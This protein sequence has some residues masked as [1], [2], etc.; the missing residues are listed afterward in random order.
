[1]VFSYTRILQ[2]LGS[3]RARF[4]STLRVENITGTSDSATG[5]PNEKSVIG[6]T[7]VLLVHNQTEENND[8][9]AV[10]ASENRG[11]ATNEAFETQNSETDEPVAVAQLPETANDVDSETADTLRTTAISAESDTDT[12]AATDKYSSKPET[13][14]THR[15]DCVTGGVNNGNV[16]NSVE[17]PKDTDNAT[18]KTICEVNKRISGLEI[19]GISNLSAEGP[20]NTV[21]L[22]SISK[23][24][25]S[26]VNEQK[27]Y[28]EK[29]PDMASDNNLSAQSNPDTTQQMNTSALRRR[30]DVRSRAE[31]HLT[32]SF[33][34]VIL[35]FVVCWFPFCVTMFI[36]V[37]STEQIPRSADITTIM[38][39]C[40]NSCCNPI[41]Y[42]VMN[43]KYRVGFAQLFCCKNPRR[44]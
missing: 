28:G 25:T 18:G 14:N 39:A 34:V 16:R 23:I 21:V 15:I 41:I 40:L 30:K 24:D 38:L 11:D 4:L 27:S 12:D 33:L 32:L 2:K 35:V 36:S 26:E 43:H 5:T 7:G 13:G 1:M 9:Q 3:I 31:I 6:S 10:E 17:T 22:L 44:K 37:H 8:G 42:G 19:S 29:R 20:A